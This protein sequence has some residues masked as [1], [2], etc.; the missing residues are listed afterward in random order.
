M[1]RLN[2]IDLGGGPPF[3]LQLHKSVCP[4][5]LHA[6]LACWV[7]GAPVDRYHTQLTRD[8]QTSTLYASGTSTICS[9]IFAPS[10]FHLFL[11]VPEM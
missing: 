10:F 1:L 7:R 11:L 2:H 6:Q 5:H 4:A 9:N 8:R 3:V